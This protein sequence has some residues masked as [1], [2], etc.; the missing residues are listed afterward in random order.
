MTETT[1]TETTK[2]VMHL[3]VETRNGGVESRICSF[4]DGSVHETAWENYADIEEQYP[5][6]LNV[7]KLSGFDVIEIKPVG[8][9]TEK[10]LIP[11]ERFVNI[12]TG[13]GFSADKY[14]IS[15]PG[16]QSLV[17]AHNLRGENTENVIRYVIEYMRPGDS[18][19]FSIVGRMFS[20]V[21]GTFTLTKNMH[22]DGLDDVEYDVSDQLREMLADYEQSITE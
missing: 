3:W 18:A 17:N 22:T 1:N 16:G 4:R 8:T 10:K 6:I 2:P 9:E 19:T 5:T 7:A 14:V 12:L 15:T 11:F 21:L 20:K 13:Y